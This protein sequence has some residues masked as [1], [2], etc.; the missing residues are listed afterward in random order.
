VYFPPHSL[1]EAACCSYWL[2]EI[3]NYNVGMDSSDVTF[4]QI[5][6]NHMSAVSKVE[7]GTHAHTCTKLGYLMNLFVP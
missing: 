4:I 7:M 6:V 5:F 1:V 3:I 2:Q